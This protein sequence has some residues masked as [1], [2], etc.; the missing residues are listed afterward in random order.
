MTVVMKPL[1]AWRT[2]MNKTSVLSALKRGETV[3]SRT[4][5]WQI[6]LKGG[7][8]IAHDVYGSGLYVPLESPLHFKHCF[9]KV[10]D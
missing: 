6:V 4:T 2:Q 7:E 1:G 8:L 9:I 5:R 10:S 3:C